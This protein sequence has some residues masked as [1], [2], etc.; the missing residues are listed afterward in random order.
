[1][2]LF[3]GILLPMLEPDLTHAVS[4]HE[5]AFVDVSVDSVDVTFTRILPD[6]IVTVVSK[7]G[8]FFGI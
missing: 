4:S 1:M 5:T 8:F 6:D 7:V 3:E 2:V